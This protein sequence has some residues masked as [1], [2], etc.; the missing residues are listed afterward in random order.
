MSCQKCRR[1]WVPAP[2]LSTFSSPIPREAH[3]ASPVPQEGEHVQA[4]QGGQTQEH[5]VDVLQPPDVQQVS[6]AEAV[7]GD[8][9]HHHDERKEQTLQLGPELLLGRAA[10]PVLLVEDPQHVGLQGGQHGGRHDDHAAHDVVEDLRRWRN[11]AAEVEAM[12]GIAAAEA[13]V[14]HLRPVGEVDDARRHHQHRHPQEG[15]AEQGM[16]P[17]ELRLVHALVVER[18][19]AHD[20]DDDVEDEGHVHVDVDHA[21]DHPAPGVAQQPVVSGVVVDPKGHGDQEEEVGEDEVEHSHRGDGRGAGLEDVRHQAQA[22]GA[23]EQ[24]H[25]V[26]GHQGMVVLM[27]VWAFSFRASGFSSAHLWKQQ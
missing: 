14:V 21:A 17:P 3:V 15:A 26:D 10:L 4:V 20:E 9:A 1:Q 12:R 25:R 13:L 11:V 5:L 8:E 6:H 27:A 2:S 7:V 24:H 19:Q 22:D 18:H 23:G 16:D